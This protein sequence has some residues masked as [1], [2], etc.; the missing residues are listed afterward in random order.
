L[1]NVPHEQLGPCGLLNCLRDDRIGSRPTAKIFGIAAIFVIAVLPVYLGLVDLTKMSL[2]QR[3]PWAILTILGPIGGFFIWLGLWRYW[4]RVD[5][6]SRWMKRASFFV[7]LVGLWYGAI[8]YF[9]WVYL[10]QLSR[11]I[12]LETWESCSDEYLKACGP[13]C[14][15]T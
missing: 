10:P 4:L 9:L 2:W 7:L 5:D 1:S 15:Q 8:V 11:K 13:R 14:L 12:K 6:S 3:F